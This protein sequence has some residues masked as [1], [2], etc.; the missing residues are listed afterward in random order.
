MAIIG[1][2]LGSSDD[3][4][5]SVT[6]SVTRLPQRL[7]LIIGCRSVSQLCCCLSSRI[8]IEHGLICNNVDF[9]T[10]TFIVFSHLR[11]G[12]CSSTSV[13][14]FRLQFGSSSFRNEGASSRFAVGASLTSW[15][16]LLRLL[17]FICLTWR[18]NSKDLVQELILRWVNCKWES[19][20]LEKRCSW[21]VS[22]LLC[23]RDKP[24]LCRQLCPADLGWRVGVEVLTPGHYSGHVVIPG[25]VETDEVVI[26]AS[27]HSSILFL[28]QETN[29]CKIC[30]T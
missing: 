25:S 18:K 15:R 17:V 8:Q 21:S 14:H 22:I 9:E 10:I 24:R 20:P 16:T 5:V 7:C 28:T 26:L 30:L 1:H 23:T 12:L 6:A 11:F 2:V 4:G 19:D 29:H 13:L 3:S 27:S